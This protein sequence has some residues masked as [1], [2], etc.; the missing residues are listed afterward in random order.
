M[1]IPGP[2]FQFKH[3]GNKFDFLHAVNSP[4]TSPVNLKEDILNY[5]GK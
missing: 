3:P 4:K 5:P 2:R 1:K